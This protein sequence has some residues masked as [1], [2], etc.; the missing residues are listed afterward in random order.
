MPHATARAPQPDKQKGRPVAGRPLTK[1]VINGNTADSTTH[2]RLQLLAARYGI[3]GGYAATLAALAWGG[4]N[5][6]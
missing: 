2:L 6:G 5:H 4:C 1:L 3:G